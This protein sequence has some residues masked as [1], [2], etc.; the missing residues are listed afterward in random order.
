MDATLSWSSVTLKFHR[1]DSQHAN[2]EISKQGFTNLHIIRLMFRFLVTRQ[3]AKL[4]VTVSEGQSEM[5]AEH[6]LWC[7]LKGSAEKKKKKKKIR[8]V[9]DQF[10]IYSPS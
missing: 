9:S 7:L 10:Q 8:Q 2:M 1:G 6:P 5:E 4:E 3:S